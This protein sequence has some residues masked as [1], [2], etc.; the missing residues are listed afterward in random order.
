MNTITIKTELLPSTGK[1]V[2][3]E[4]AEWQMMVLGKYKS[5]Q[6]QARQASTSFGRTIIENTALG[7]A[8]E[9]LHD[10]IT[11]WTKEE[12]ECNWVEV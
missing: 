9:L 5:L 3:K 11:P 1:P 10:P 7:R 2:S 4:V 6:V 8:L 12:L